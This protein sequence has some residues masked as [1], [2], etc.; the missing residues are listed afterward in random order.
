MIKTII[1]IA[2]TLVITWNIVTFAQESMTFNPTKLSV[3]HDFNLKK[4]ENDLKTITNNNITLTEHFIENQINAIYFKNP[5]VTNC[6]IYAH[7][8]SDTIEECIH[9]LY[10]FGQYCNIILFD[11][12][13][14]GKSSGTPSCKKICDDGFKVWLYATHDLGFK[15]DNI[16][17]YG[18]SLG[19]AV[20]SHLAH[21]VNHTLD[22]SPVKAVIVQS[23]FSSS[24]QMAKEMFP[25]PIYHF[26]KLFMDHTLD[27]ERYLKKLNDKTKIIIM[28]SEEDE[29]IGFHHSKMLANDVV[30]IKGSHNI[31]E[32]TQEFWN[33]FIDCL[34]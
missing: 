16:I 18:F 2:A 6:I 11:Y 12:S 28:H 17:L 5:N 25:I 7:G 24:K 4:H 9:F 31:P 32:F 19:G 15:S 23:S 3:T 21:T 1:I 26:L 27:S 30:I 33:R 34:Q 14:Y 20:V 29:M 13:G 22:N 8:N 10:E